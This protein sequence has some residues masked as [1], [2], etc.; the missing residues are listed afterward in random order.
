LDN[1]KLILNN[2]TKGDKNE[3]DNVSRFSNCDDDD[4]D[5]DDA[6]IVCNGRQ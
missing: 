2:L 5:D 1:G 6:F 3:E 4:D